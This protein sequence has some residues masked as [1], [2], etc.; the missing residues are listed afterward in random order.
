MAQNAGRS[1]GTILAGAKQP[2]AFIPVFWSALGA[3]LRYCGNTLNGW[4]GLVI[5][6]E[7]N[8]YKFA[9]YY[10]KGETVVAMAS[11][12]MDPAMAKSVDLML[13][14]EMPTKSELEAGKDPLSI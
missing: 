14:G 13:R 5:K 9:A 10:T 7:P 1:V 3:Q 8:E 4:D 12:G 6:G 2:K 11:M